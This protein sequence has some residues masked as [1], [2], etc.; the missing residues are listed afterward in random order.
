MRRRCSPLP[1]SVSDTLRVLSRCI[2]STPPT[3][4]LPA[5]PSSA[6]GVYGMPWERTQVYA[7]K[8]DE[9]R[10]AMELSAEWVPCQCCRFAR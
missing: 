7:R 8:A 9:R 5:G 10:R 1:E 2:P 6:P 3:L 4:P